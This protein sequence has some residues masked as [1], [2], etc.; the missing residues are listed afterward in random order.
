MIV[1]LIAFALAGTGWARAHSQDWNCLGP[2]PSVT[3]ACRHV[4]PHVP[5]WPDERV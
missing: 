3:A 5:G 2:Q 1:L 4:P